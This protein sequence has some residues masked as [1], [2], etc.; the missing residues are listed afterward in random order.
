MGPVFGI[1]AIWTGILET[2]GGV[3]V[4]ARGAAPLLTTRFLRLDFS[5]SI[6][7]P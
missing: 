5:A 7:P 6:S 2:F 4:Q 3:G 1:A